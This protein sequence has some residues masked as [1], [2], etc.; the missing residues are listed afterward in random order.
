[1]GKQD[2]SASAST[3]Y[4]HGVRGLAVAI[5]LAGHC[6][7]AGLHLVPGL[8]LRATAKAGVWLFFIL[9]AYLLTPKLIVGFESR[10]I[11]AV[12]RHFA[13]RR[14]FRILP[15]YYAVL[16]G[17]AVIGT[18]GMG[19]L[20]RHIVLVA[21]REH[22]WTIPVEMAFYAV[23]PLAAFALA[24]LNPQVR[25]WIGAL[26]FAVSMAIYFLVGPKGVAE[27]SLALMHY[28]PFF[29]AGMGLCLLPP[30][31]SSGGGTALVIVSLLAMP[32]VSPRVL[33]A[34]SGTTIEQALSWSWMFAIG[35]TVFLYGA[36]SSRFVRILLSYSWAV[37]LGKVSFGVYLIHYQLTV[38]ASEWDWLSPAL[39]GWGVVVVSIACATLSLRYFEDPILSWAT[40][41][42]RSTV[43]SEA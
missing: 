22:F 17:L 5:V 42:K 38:W 11:L 37:H 34:L 9:S 8:D 35:W 33:V 15:L 1:M 19:E 18:M 14:I 3:E 23:L 26:L 12:V 27:N 43:A 39:R 31:K 29:A 36:N 25:P 13:L 4:L 21:G 2:T 32:F 40:K 41:P 6:S 30:M 16:I 7:N 20:F 24:N 10:P 28:G